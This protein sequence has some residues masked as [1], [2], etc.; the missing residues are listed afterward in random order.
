MFLERIEGLCYEH[1]TNITSVLKELGL[2]SSKGTAWQNGTIPK[3]DILSKLANHFSVT[4]DYLLG[5][6][7]DPN[8]PVQLMEG[9][10]YAF[11]EGWK[12]LDDDER[13]ELNRAA[14]RMLEVKRLREQQ[15]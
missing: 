2:S 6:T 13:A 1:E 9:L 8:P 5:R 3:G 7:D 4:T 15:Q 14:Q 12:E 11:I 10:E